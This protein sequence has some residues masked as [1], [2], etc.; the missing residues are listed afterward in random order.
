LQLCGSKPRPHCMLTL[1][2][3]STFSERGQNKLI[4]E[5]GS[6]QGFKLINLEIV[7]I[8]KI[9]DFYVV[10]IK[11]IMSDNFKFFLPLKNSFSWMDAIQI[12]LN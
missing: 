11:E 3:F 4:K 6:P 8:I 7:S 10:G 2:E 1:Q 5:Y 12:H 9:Y